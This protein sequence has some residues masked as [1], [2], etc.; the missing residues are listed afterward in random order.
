MT[1]LAESWGGIKKPWHW[2][3]I[4]GGILLVWAAVAIPHLNRSRDAADAEFRHEPVAG[5]IAQ[6]PTMTKQ[7]F[8]A[9]EQARDAVSAGLKSQ[10]S[11]AVVEGRKIVRTTSISMIVQSPADVAEKIGALAES[12]GGYLERADGGGE[13]ATSGS[14]TIRVPAARFEEARAQIRKLG[15]KVENEQVEAQDVTR[16]YVDQ[17]ANLRNLRAEE[18]GYL[19]ILK[20]A[21]TV[22]DMLAV[23][24]QL[25][26]VRGQIEQ[27]Q[28]EFNA[29]SRQIET[30]AI[31]I[32]LRKEVEP[33][34]LGV[35]WHPGYVLRLAFRDGMESL[36]DYAASMTTILFNLPAALLWIGTILGTIVAGWKIVRWAG[37]RWFGWRPVEVV[38]AK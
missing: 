16:Q 2:M 17:D 14:L 24:E 13:N 31:S 23:S 32:S 35:H 10:P 15:V 20:Q 21:H 27:Q 6:S 29:L 5:L 18:A 33:Q 26:N 7:L 19:E 30:V 25:S 22:K 11:P 34:V 36:G 28:A 38:E 9:Q 37:R 3:A 4:G 12:M 8:V 1:T